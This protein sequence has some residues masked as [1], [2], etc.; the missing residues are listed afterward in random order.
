MID[1]NKALIRKA[2]TEADYKPVIAMHFGTT[3]TGKLLV[4]Y[5]LDSTYYHNGIEKPEVAKEY[6]DIAS[7]QPHEKGRW[8][9]FVK[10]HINGYKFQ[11]PMMRNQSIENVIRN[12]A[13][14]DCPE[15]ITHRKNDK[16]FSVINRRKFKSGRETTAN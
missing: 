15:Y 7:K 3:Q 4:T 10:Q 11:Q 12:K 14:F 5:Q 1:P 9:G 2:Y 13:M 6:Y 16:G 8:Y